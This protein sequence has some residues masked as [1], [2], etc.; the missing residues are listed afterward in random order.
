MFCDS[1]GASIVRNELITGSIY[2]LKRLATTPTVGGKQRN[3][4]A[5]LRGGTK[6][7]LWRDP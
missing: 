2:F 5:A 1:N 7:E 4:A 3:G 6:F